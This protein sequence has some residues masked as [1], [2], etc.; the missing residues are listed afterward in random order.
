MKSLSELKSIG[1]K[2]IFW[3]LFQTLLA[4]I[5]GMTIAVVSGIGQGS[6]LSIVAGFKAAKIPPFT[7][8]ITDL[9]SNNLFASMAEG[10]VIPVVF[11]AIIVGI[12]VVALSGKHE[13]AMVTFKKFIDDCHAI[14]YAIIRVVISLLP[15]SIIC[16]MADTMGTSDLNALKPLV[17]IILLAFVG[18]FFHVF[19]TDSLLLRFVGKLSPIRF[20]KGVMPAQV[21]AFSSRSSSGTLPL[22]VTCV[23]KNVGV[24]ENIAN[25]VGSLGTTVG[26][27]GCAGVWPPL[28]AVYAIHSMGGQ[29]SLAQAI[30]IILLC[31]IISLGTA[32][33][34]GGGIMLATAMFV[35][36]GPPV[37]L[38]SIF[39]GI[40]A[41]VDMARTMT[42]VTSSMVAST[43]V[44]K[45][46]GSL[47]SV[48]HAK[49]VT[50]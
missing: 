14:V 48:H 28:L 32:G 42:N 31:P 16:L 11:F 36:L 27:S 7:Q 43:L 19:V 33:V 49:P 1:G 4:A 26:M 21:M 25:F 10:K 40:D 47:A 50:N 6:H 17:T 12:A 9:F 15:Y 46:E 44:A 2:S 35:T 3:L 20:F 34:P 45:S 13:G 8:V 41:F 38:I 22:Y 29:V 37:G 23:T 5:V 39:A 30:V 24:P 18:C